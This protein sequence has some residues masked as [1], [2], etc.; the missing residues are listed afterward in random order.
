MNDNNPS[1]APKENLLQSAFAG[2]LW[3]SNIDE[4]VRLME[5]IEFRHTDNDNSRWMFR[6]RIKSPELYNSSCHVHFGHYGLGRVL[7]CKVYIDYDDS[8][9]YEKHFDFYLK[10]LTDKYG[11]AK[12]INVNKEEAIWYHVDDLNIN[13]PSDKIRL[14]K[15]ARHT[16][17]IIYYTHPNFKKE[18]D[19]AILK[20]Q[21]FLKA[22]I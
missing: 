11:D 16:N 7:D 6:G 12:F 22:I 19:A 13:D 5:E 3:D 2:V 15:D 8:A 9:E 21:N 14:E 10:T 18:M 20:K 1:I 17:L 4:V